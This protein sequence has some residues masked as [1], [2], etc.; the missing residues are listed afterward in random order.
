VG[1]GA[2]RGACGGGRRREGSGGEEAEEERREEPGGTPAWTRGGVGT[3]VFR[4]RELVG[5]EL[6]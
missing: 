6:E 3:G 5:L 1:R 4:L 2:A